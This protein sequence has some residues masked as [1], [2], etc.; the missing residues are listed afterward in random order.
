MDFQEVGFV[1]MG[2]I[3]LAKERDKCLGIYES[4]RENSCSI[5][6]GVIINYLKTG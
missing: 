5:K 3:E 1:V 2:W 6:L 4:S